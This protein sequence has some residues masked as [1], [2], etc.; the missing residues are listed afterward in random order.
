MLAGTAAA[1]RGKVAQNATK[2]SKTMFKFSPVDTL[3][4][5]TFDKLQL[6]NL[7]WLIFSWIHRLYDYAI[8]L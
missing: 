5:Y 1:R 3:T 4:L 2:R 8:V 6:Y 7:K